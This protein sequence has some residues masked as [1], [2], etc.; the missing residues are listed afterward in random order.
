MINKKKAMAKLIHLT[1]KRE[2][3]TAVAAAE[4]QPT[5]IYLCNSPLPACKTFTP[6]YI[7]LAAKYQNIQFCI[8]ELT[9]ETSFMFKFA[10]NQLPVLVLMVKKTWCRTMMGANVKE[11]E[12]GLGDLLN[13]AKTL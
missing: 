6:R 12:A 1:N 2:H 8:M 11:L 13:E 7:E 10:P 4:M 9:S 5:V 3:D